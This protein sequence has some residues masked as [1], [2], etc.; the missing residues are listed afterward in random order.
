MKCFYRSER[1]RERAVEE[2]QR[3]RERRVDWRR[4]RE[5]W[6]GLN[7]EWHDL[8]QSWTMRWLDLGWTSEGTA[9]MRSKRFKSF[10]LLVSRRVLKD[11]NGWDSNGWVLDR[12]MWVFEVN[13]SFG[14][15][16][17]EEVVLVLIEVWEL[18]RW[19][20]WFCFESLRALDC[21]WWW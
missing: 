12:L 2:I 20:N 1:E 17:E 8:N 15:S 19:W 5:R 6:W 10:K 13:V 18:M 11:W 9:W 14:I 21:R 4:R 7:Y 3:E 16:K